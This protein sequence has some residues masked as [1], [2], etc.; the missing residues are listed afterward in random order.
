MRSPNPLMSQPPNHLRWALSVVLGNLI[1]LWVSVTVRWRFLLIEVGL[2]SGIVM[3]TASSE[4]PKHSIHDYIST[5][6]H[7][8]GVSVTNQ[9]Q[10]WQ[11]WLTYRNICLIMVRLNFTPKLMNQFKNTRTVT[12]SSLLSGFSGS[13][14]SWNNQPINRQVDPQIINQQ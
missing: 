5:Y 7:T 14:Y 6:R 2:W 8:Q 12:T 4:P 11:I 3:V 9:W 13:V 1:A 10:H